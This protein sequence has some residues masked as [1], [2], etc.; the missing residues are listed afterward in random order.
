MLYKP[1]GSTQEI[2]S[3]YGEIRQLEQEIR[4]IQR[5]LGK[6]N[7]LVTKQGA[8]LEDVD[9][10]D[11]KLRGFHSAGRSLEH[12]KNL[13]DTYIDLNGAQSKLSQLEELP[14]FPDD[15]LENLK[16][17]KKEWE[18]LDEQIKEKASDFKVLE[19]RRNVCVYNEELINLEPTVISLQ[20]QSEKYRSAS[21]DIIFVG[22]KRENLEDKIKV[23]T[24][25]RGEDWSKDIIREF[26]L[27]H[28]D[29]DKIHI[30]KYQLEK[31][32]KKISDKK[33]K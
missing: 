27:K 8:L 30:L 21:K 1:R 24:N 14:D 13:F 17:F 6:Y 11:E 16:E 26:K 12:K 19:T 10:L 22:S 5:G 15:A 33:T 7:D 4:E 2:H 9:N 28:L 29:R 18:N 20:T 23:E 32:N 3:L 25:K 31:D